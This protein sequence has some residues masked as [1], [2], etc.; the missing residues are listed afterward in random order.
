MDIDTKLNFLTSWLKNGFKISGKYYITCDEMFLNG[1]SVY[2][3]TA[4]VC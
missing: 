2:T 4:R 3:K 1:K